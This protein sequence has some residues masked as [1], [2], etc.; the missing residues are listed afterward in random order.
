M[1]NKDHEVDDR[2]G[3][4]MRK[5]SLCVEK[6]VMLVSFNENYQS[7]FQRRNPKLLRDQV[8]GLRATLGC[9]D[10]CLAAM[11]ESIV[12]NFPASFPKKREPTKS[13]EGEKNG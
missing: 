4:R 13:K 7:A 2:R 5:L 9:V 8:S 12:K 1:S 10:G 11:E 6:A 3:R